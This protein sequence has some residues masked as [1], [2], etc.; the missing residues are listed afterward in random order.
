MLTGL[1]RNPT[2]I[3]RFRHNLLKIF[4]SDHWS[5][6]AIKPLTFSSWPMTNHIIT[7]SHFLSFIVFKLKHLKINCFIW[8]TTRNVYDFVQDSI[9]HGAP[10]D[11]SPSSCLAN[12]TGWFWIHNYQHLLVN[13][14]G[15][16]Q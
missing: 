14:I 8:I 15:N 2:L 6:L 4:S 7:Q 3:P 11:I 13:K 12:S 5:K 10:I 16:G 1:L 9:N